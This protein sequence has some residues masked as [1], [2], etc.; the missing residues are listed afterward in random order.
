MGVSAPTPGRTFRRLLA[1]ITAVLL[2]FL[3]AAGLV[4]GIMAYLSAGEIYDYQDSVDGVH[5]PRVDAIVCLAGGRGR[6]AAAGDLWYRYWEQSQYPLGRVGRTFSPEKPPVFYLSGTGPLAN[7]SVL[8]HQVRRGVL[9]ILKPV[10]VVME[11]HSTNTEENARWLVRY[12]R[13]RGWEKVLMITSPYHM[14]RAK[15]I[16]EEV[17]RA[18]GLPI[19][20][21]T[22]SV[23]QEPFEPGEWKSGLHGIRVTIIE[24]LK[25]LYYHSFW[26]ADREELSPT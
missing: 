1:Q 13:Q 18:E 7:W 24:Y 23:Y 20:I 4:G 21:E 16:F 12:A 9:D 25:W 5:L 2:F 26:K 11:N 14:K 19:T 15:W 17:F 3:L 8:A 6:I 10:D 22:L